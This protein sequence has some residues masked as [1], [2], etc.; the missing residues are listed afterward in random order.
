M[1][2]NDERILSSAELHKDLNAERK[3]QGLKEM[4]A[5]N[6]GKGGSTSTYARMDKSWKSAPDFFKQMIKKEKEDKEEA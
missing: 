5:V 1:S 3:K 4:P 2:K 6:P